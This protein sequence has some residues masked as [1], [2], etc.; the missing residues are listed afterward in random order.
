MKPNTLT[1]TV[2]SVSSSLTALPTAKIVRHPQAK[3][4]KGDL[5]L[6]PPDEETIQRLNSLA[7]QHPFCIRHKGTNN[8]LL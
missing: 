8:S 4:A 1:A 2:N 5:M 3:K 7:K 6:T